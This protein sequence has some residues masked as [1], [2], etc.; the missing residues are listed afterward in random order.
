MRI[1]SLRLLLTHYLESSKPA[2]VLM[3]RHCRHNASGGHWPQRAIVLLTTLLIG[4]ILFLRLPID[5]TSSIS[6]PGGKGAPWNQTI[7]AHAQFTRFGIIGE[8]HSG[9]NYI[10]GWL[11]KNFKDTMESE[12]F[13]KVVFKHW[14]LTPRYGQLFK[15]LRRANLTNT[16][17]V[18]AV[19]DPC[20]WLTAMYALP[21]HNLRSCQT[22]IRDYLMRPFVGVHHSAPFPHK[23]EC[24]NL[25]ALP[26]MEREVVEHGQGNIMTLRAKKLQIWR[27]E[28]PRIVPH[29]HLVRFEDIR[30]DP[31]RVFEDLL[32]RFPKLR[33]TAKG[34]PRKMRTVDGILSPIG[35]DGAMGT[36]CFHIAGKSNHRDAGRVVTE[37]N[38]G[39]DW[40]LEGAFGY[41]TKC[42]SSHLRDMLGDG[43]HYAKKCD[44]RLVTGP[45]MTSAPPLLYPKLESGHE[46]ESES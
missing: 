22:S 34:K 23:P 13:K 39:I 30:E 16:L 29:L 38:L 19:R 44:E 41:S 14:W 28:L 1:S 26:A 27:K 8:R 3:L 4:V 9:T 31:K 2:V 43:A 5:N 46:S 42:R 7:D 20:A 10:E 37:M 21:H 24:G 12:S 45:T 11:S 32:E 36:V 17:V 35:E 6:S 15:R 33:R 18:V 40:I 25:S